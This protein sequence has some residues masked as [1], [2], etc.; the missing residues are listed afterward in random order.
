MG[1][2]KLIKL[3]IKKESRLVLAESC[4]GGL[5]SAKCTQIAGSS[6]WFW[7][8]L[9]TYSVDAKVDWLGVDPELVTCEGIVSEAVAEAMARGALGCSPAQVALSVTGFAGPEGGDAHAD[10]GDVCFGLAVRDG[11]VESVKMHFEGV[12]DAV[13]AQACDA[14]FEWAN[15]MLGIN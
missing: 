1:L 3:L 4:T 15:T 13:R 11:A 2:E 5:M 14:I 9:V 12:R 10:I 8:S 7:G 6:H